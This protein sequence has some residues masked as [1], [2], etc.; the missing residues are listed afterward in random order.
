[1][2][3][4]ERQIC[5]EKGCG[6]IRTQKRQLLLL[7][8]RQRLRRIFANPKF[9]K[10]FTYPATRKKGDGDIWDAE[11]MEN[12]DEMNYGRN[13]IELILSSDGCVYESWNKTTLTPVIGQN[14]NW[15]PGARTCFAGLLL[16]AVF[17]PKVVY[18]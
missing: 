1:M 2:P 13:V 15:P 12:V 11:V 8:V 3:G 6:E 5:P 10:L 14:V 16:F 17:P 18:M 4:D 9:A 7:N